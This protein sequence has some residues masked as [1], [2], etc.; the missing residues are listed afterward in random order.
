MTVWK[1][2]CGDTNGHGIKDDWFLMDTITLILQLYFTFHPMA[3]DVIVP[4]SHPSF[5]L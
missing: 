3:L 1:Q 2:E 4:L 5:S